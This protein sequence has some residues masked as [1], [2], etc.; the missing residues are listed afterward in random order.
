MLNIQDAEC[1]DRKAHL[2]EMHKVQHVPLCLQ[3][4]WMLHEI[5][6]CVKRLLKI[7]QKVQVK[8]LQKDNSTFAVCFVFGDVFYSIIPVDLSMSILRLWMFGAWKRKNPVVHYSG[9]VVNLCN[10]SFTT[11]HLSNVK[12]NFFSWGDA[13]LVS[14][15][16]LPLYSTVVLS[17]AHDWTRNLQIA[18]W[19]LYLLSH[20]TTT[21]VQSVLKIWFD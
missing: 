18:R 13:D 19:Q 17:T 3:K 14:A 15:S 9:H 16:L 6:S 21:V 1:L 7:S 8:W 4:L 2:F 12:K 10:V 11:E 20:V 5:P